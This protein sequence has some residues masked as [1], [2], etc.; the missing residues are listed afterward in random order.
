MLTAIA[1]VLSEK[2]ESF[3]PRFESRFDEKFQLQE[4]FNTPEYKEFAH[5]MF[6]NL[7]GGIGFFHGT[8]LVDK[9]YADEYA[10]DDEGFWEGTQK[11]LKNADAQHVGPTSLFTSIPSRPFFPRGFYWDEGFQLLPILDWDTDLR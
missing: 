6:S 2:I 10:E 1:E 11:A 3:K 9:S 4:P 5:N 7:L 8:S